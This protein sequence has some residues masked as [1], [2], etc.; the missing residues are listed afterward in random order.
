VILRNGIAELP[1]SGLVDLAVGPR[2]RYTGWW[3][4]LRLRAAGGVEVSV[5]LLADQ[6]DE[7]TWRVLQAELRR[8]R[9]HGRSAS[10]RQRGK[11]DR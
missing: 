2:S 9:H 11:R 6:L 10:P 5:V 1:D 7:D 3:V 4:H 8:T